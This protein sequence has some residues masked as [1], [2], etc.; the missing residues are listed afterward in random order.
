M[1][2]YIPTYKRPFNQRTYDFLEKSWQGRVTFV[3]H[4]SEMNHF[5]GKDFVVCDKV[6]APEFRERAV[7]DAMTKERWTIF[8]FDDD[9]RFSM[10]T[11]DWTFENPKLVPMNPEDLSAALCEVE[12]VLDSGKY[13]LVG[14]A[15]RGFNNGERCHPTR[16]NT[17]IMRAFGVNVAVLLEEN[18]VFNKYPYWEDFHVTLSLLTRGYA[19]LVFTKFCNDGVTNAKGGVSEYRTRETLI[20][21]RK[22]FLK[23]WGDY[24]VPVE[25]GSVG[26]GK[27]DE[28]TMP[29]LKID[30]AKAWRNRK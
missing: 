17:R 1:H 9:L 13:A 19:N 11:P 26:W 7:L 16:E 30:W 8:M 18:I 24:V 10:R 25:K 22:D 20:E 6:G 27:T 4:P 12:Q 5:I 23:E 29:D 28:V 14:F 15:P 3:V 2:L 21:T